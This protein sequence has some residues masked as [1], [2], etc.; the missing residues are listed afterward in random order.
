MGK[1]F[2]LFVLVVNLAVSAPGQLADGNPADRAKAAAALPAAA[3][4]SNAQVI[5]PK[6]SP[7]GSKIA[8]LFPLEDWRALGVFERA[9]G[10]ARLVLQASNESLDS[11]LW[12]GNSHLIAYADYHGNQEPD[13]VLTD[14]SGK[15]VVKLNDR[16]G[17]GGIIDA[18]PDDPECVVATTW[19]RGMGGLVQLI[20]VLTGK[21]D[22]IFLR[23]EGEWHASY[24]GFVTDREGN[25]RFLGIY[26]D[27][28][29]SFNY[30]DNPTRPFAKLLSWPVHGYAELVN[31][32]VLAAD[33]RS[34]YIV[35]R[36]QHDRGAL[37]R[38]DTITRQWGEPIFVPPEGE[39]K[40][41][42][43]SYDNRC[44]YGVSYEGAR[45]MY[46]WFDPERAALQ[47][48]LEASFPGMDVEVVSQS[49]D[50]QVM[51]VL[52]ESDRE[53]G[54]YFLLDRTAKSVA[55]FK[56][57]LP[58]LEARLLRPMEPITLAARDGL[59]LHGYL[60]RPWAAAAGQRV[61]LVIVPHGGPFGIRDSWGFDSE[62][63]FL[64]SRGYAV[65]QLNYR[66]SGGY[67]RAFIDRGKAQW[68]RA[69]Q[70]DL[71]DGVRWAIAQGIADP[72]RVAIYGTSYGGF[73]AL[74]G[75]TLTP[76][77]YCC[78]VNCVGPTDLEITFHYRG[79][80][81][82]MSTEDYDFRDEWVGP[83]RKY[84]A[85]KSPIRM[86]ERIRVPTFHAY[87][88]ND[89]V[90]EFDHWTRLNRE[91]KRLNKPFESLIDKDQGHGFDRGKASIEF[92]E[93]LDKFLAAH[94]A[95]K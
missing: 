88:K 71:T 39:I 90:V 95:A 62:V 74:A 60:T 79:S 68:G 43:F 56:R 78:A 31:R 37:Y 80:D 85:E 86:I 94:L 93:R 70:D 52:V 28:Q 38:F 76:D 92:Y 16:Y 41:M 77:L 33:G 27:K 75:V 15:Q 83:T 46:H 54:A 53:P 40:S 45:T 3:F 66:G 26:R 1:C 65:L 87:G 7:D 73:A 10:D 59:E 35:A 4:F 12:K 32:V 8:F 5:E 50:E 58:G 64:A 51:I 82:Y 2:W 6:L 14:L 34:A 84:R 20:N 17:I 11:L 89:P 63:Q 9:T 44:L 67:G 13:I 48:S 49:A 57:R 47:A 69:M 23:P 25:V 19:D 42:I 29:L 61:P 24:S 18:R 55:L 81:A 21:S 22:T 91:L 30:R 36:I 72:A